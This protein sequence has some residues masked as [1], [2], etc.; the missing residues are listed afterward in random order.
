MNGV[1]VMQWPT[2]RFRATLVLLAL[3]LTLAVSAC[4]SSSA[5]SATS[6]SS[7]TATATATTAA[8]TATATATT[9]P[10]TAT[11]PPPVAK[12]SQV[13]GFGNAGAAS[14][15]V[16]FT[17]V[18]FPSG[19][20]SYVQQKFETNS[21]QFKLIAA[22][23]PSSS[24]SSVRAF[25]TS[26]LPS[27]QFGQSNTFPYHGNPSS[28]CGDPYCWSSLVT[29]YGRYISLENVKSA[30]SVAVYT[31]RL[32]IAPRTGSATIQGTYTFHFDLG[33]TKDDLWWEQMTAT[34][35]E[36]AQASGST[37]TFVNIG[38]TN[39]NNVTAAQLK[40]LH[41]GTTPIDGSDGTSK[42]VTGD[43]F[44]V[45]DTFGNYVKVEVL[46]YN[47]STHALQLQWVI[48]PAT[49]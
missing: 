27:H 7:G 15:G 11:P 25:Y 40:G 44:A 2:A 18:P 35:R 14:A 16:N 33:E 9:A 24:A 43:V 38:V 13:A 31:L 49:F 4:S 6:S 36:L 34:Q 45:I 8:A 22:C 19:A 30:G 47:S 29:E 46:G 23:A 41:Y 26:N 3:T 28:A 39:F 1:I 20:V 37:A 48:Y 12:C 10:P 5:T 42:L 21:Y 32:A 17:A